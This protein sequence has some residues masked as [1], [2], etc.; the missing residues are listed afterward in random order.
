LT[1]TVL[2]GDLLPILTANLSEGEAFQGIPLA[3]MRLAQKGDP[4]PFGD[5]NLF[6]GRSDWT[7]MRRS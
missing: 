2:V 5:Y 7:S 4:R 6:A 1:S 3:V